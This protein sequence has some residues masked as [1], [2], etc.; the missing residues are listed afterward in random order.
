M[1]ESCHSPRQHCHNCKLLKQE[2]EMLQAKLLDRQKQIDC[3]EATLSEFQHGF[4]SFV[5]NHQ[6]QISAQIRTMD[7]CKTVANEDPG[8]SVEEG[9][10]LQPGI[11]PDSPLRAPM[12]ATTHP[13]E[14]SKDIYFNN[15]FVYGEGA[16]D[17]LALRLRSLSSRIEAVADSIPEKRDG[18]TK[19]ECYI[20][21]RKKKIAPSAFMK[22]IIAMPISTEDINAAEEDCRQLPRFV[23]NNTV[24]TMDDVD[25]S[26]E[27]NSNNANI[28]I[29]GVNTIDDC[30]KAPPSIALPIPTITTAVTAKRSTPQLRNRFS[31]SMQLNNEFEHIPDDDNDWDDLNL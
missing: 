22:P 14:I 25:Q 24:S 2:V 1:M 11:L 31:K 4:R 30:S 28:N 15:P 8:V 29:K 20:T 13:T 9:L 27:N 7:M 10:F 23:I 6:S 12:M 16:C 21:R 18:E 19:T 3:M 26:F 5:E 17:N